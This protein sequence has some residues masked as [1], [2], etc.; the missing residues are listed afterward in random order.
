MAR[1]Y[2]NFR[3]TGGRDKW[4]NC[5]P[6][7]SLKPNG[8]GLSDMVG[9]VWEWCRYDWGG[10]NKTLRGG[11]SGNHLYL[12]KIDQ[13]IGYPADSRGSSEG[14]RCVVSGLD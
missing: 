13:S 11:S 8:Y 14:F 12:L 7:E 3:G 9:N 5:S 10:T 4:V 1:E 2:T 6:V